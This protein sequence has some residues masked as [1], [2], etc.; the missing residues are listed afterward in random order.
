MEAG[1]LAIIIFGGYLLVGWVVLSF[2]RSRFK[3]AWE[4]GGYI[5]RLLIWP[6][7]LAI[8]LSRRRTDTSASGDGR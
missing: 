5:G 2:V 4:P 1:L 3:E 6:V 7:T 8:A